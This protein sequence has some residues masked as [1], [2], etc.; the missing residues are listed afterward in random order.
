[1][2]AAALSEAGYECLREAVTLARQHDIGS[3]R[4]LR[5]RLKGLGY[6]KPVIDEALSAWESHVK[7]VER[8]RK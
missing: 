6:A 3:R 1:M 8:K 7:A 4:V 5:G 2:T